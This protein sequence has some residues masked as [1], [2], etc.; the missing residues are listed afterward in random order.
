MYVTISY[1]D[2]DISNDENKENE[3]T[4]PDDDMQLQRALYLSNLTTANT[5]YTYL[6]IDVMDPG[7]IRRMNSTNDTNN[8]KMNDIKALTQDI[9]INILMVM[10]HI[11][12]VTGTY[13]IMTMVKLCL[14]QC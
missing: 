4:Y 13:I 3:N 14:L 5:H 1:T 10:N 11:K 12:Y 7:S 2:T 9:T 6:N 8:T